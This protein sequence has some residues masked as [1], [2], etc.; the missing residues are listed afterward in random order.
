[1]SHLPALEVRGNHSFLLTQSRVSPLS[2]VRVPAAEGPLL[3]LRVLHLRG[4]P[5]PHDAPR[6]L[7]GLRTLTLEVSTEGLPGVGLGHR[8]I[9]LHLRHPIIETLRWAVRFS[10][11][12]D[13]S[14]GSGN[15]VV[16]LCIKSYICLLCIF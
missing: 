2:T 8:H 14:L 4:T 10:T 5:N 16:N 3:F 12:T 7:H 13:L 11:A 15:H 6:A 1:M 9:T